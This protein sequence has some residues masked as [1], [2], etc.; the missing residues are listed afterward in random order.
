MARK[1]DMNWNLPETNSWESIT[2]A[3]LMD[4]RDRLDFTRCYDW[5]Q[6][7]TELR[8][9]RIALEKPRTTKLERFLAKRTPPSRVTYGL[10]GRRPAWGTSRR[11]SR[12]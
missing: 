1:A 3:L 9:I 8:R 6:V 7:P 12:R 5:R 2:A 11:A 4:L 10:H